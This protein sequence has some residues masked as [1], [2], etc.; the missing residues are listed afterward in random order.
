[1]APQSIEES[2]Q[3]LRQLIRARRAKSRKW[4]FWCIRRKE[5]DAFVGFTL[6]RSL[7]TGWCEW[8]IGYSLAKA[9]WGNGYAIEATKETIKFAFGPLS[10][11]RLVANV[12]P[13]NEPSMN[14]L[15]IL[16]FREEA[17]QVESYFEHG[18]WQD[19]VQLALLA[20]EFAGS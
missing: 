6:L 17:H 18:E 4:L 5:D 16:S 1:M 19:N 20:R 2:E 10:A 12:Y 7:N 8:E 13:Q 15:R 9:H 14:L 11:H 3:T